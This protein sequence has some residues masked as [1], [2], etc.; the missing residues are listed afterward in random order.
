MRLFVALDL[1]EPVRQELARAQDRLRAGRH[2]VR[3]ADPAGL[4]LTLQ[5]LGEAEGARVALLKAAIAQIP[6]APLRLELAGFGAF[7]N[8]RQPRVV[9]VGVGGD[10][11]ALKELQQSVLAAT[12][13]LGF[14][15]EDRPF[16]AHLTLGRVHSDVRPEQ[17]RALGGALAHVGPPVPV[18]WDTGG[19][20]LFQSTTTP[21]GAIY[22][23]LS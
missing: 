22:T 17:L 15:S 14:A 2:P 8:Q 20:I 5:F 6:R 7:P 12:L 4:H 23:R 3:W 10:T 16:T 18:A 21:G 19:P 9:W 13:P 1:A 11:S